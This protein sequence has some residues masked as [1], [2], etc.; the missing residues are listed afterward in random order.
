MCKFPFDNKH[1][2]GFGHVMEASLEKTLFRAQVIADKAKAYTI[3]A[4]AEKDEEKARAIAQVVAEKNAE[5]DRALADK[6]RALAEKDRALADKDCALAD[7]DR[8]LADKD[9]EKACALAEKDRALAEK[10]AEIAFLRASAAAYIV[11]SG[12]RSS[13]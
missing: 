5:K 10:D 12:D 7:K 6:D 1:A 4:I 3:S 8:A 9:I 2:Q 11:A 13:K